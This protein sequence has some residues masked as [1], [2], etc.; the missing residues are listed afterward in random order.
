MLEWYAEAGQDGSAEHVEE[1]GMYHCHIHFYFIGHHCRV[2]DMIQGTAPLD[3][4]THE[5]SESEKPDKK[6]SAKA[7]VIL[8]NLQGMDGTGDLCRILADKKKKAELIVLASR[9]Q[10]PFL[11]ESM[12]ELWDIWTMPMEDDEIRFR[13][14]RWQ[15]LCKTDKDYW[16]T[17]HYLDATINNIPNL[18]WY[19]DKDGVHEKVN[20]S[21]CQSVNKTMQQ[22]EGQRHAYIWDV[23][24]DDP[25]CIESE[26]EVMSTGKTCISE[27]TIQTGDGLRL[28]TTYKSPLYDLDGSVMGTVGIGIDITQGTYLRTGADEE[29][30]YAGSGLYFHGLR[31]HDPLSGRL[32]YSQRKQS[33]P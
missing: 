29:K 5:Y 32:P 33:S 7:D 23:E 13:I 1:K 16:Q 18:I 3:N 17:S 26:R 12:A 11:A 14:R 9:E 22:V 4:F 31:H 19:K 30:P 25:A 10:I 6:Q 2:F 24:Q 21:F 15:Q 8:L 28:L 27:E 20:E